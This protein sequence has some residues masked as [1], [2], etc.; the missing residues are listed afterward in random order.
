MSKILFIDVETAPK[1]A[2]VWGLW[3]Q[4]VGLNQLV[5][6][7]YILNWSAKW[8]DED[9]IYTDSLHYHKLWNR[10]P[11]NDRIILE[12][13]WKLLDEAD[14]VVGHNGNRFDIPTINTR[15]L[16]HG[17]Q[18]P[19]SYKK[20]DT[21]KVVRSK[22]RFTSNKLEFLA[23]K[24]LGESKIDTGGFELWRSI[25]QDH[26]TKAFDRM[27]EYCEHDVFLLEKIYKLIAPWHTNHPSTVVQNET[28]AHQCNVCGSERII[29]NG[30]YT[31]Q[32]S[33]YQKY[34]CNDCGHSMRDGTARKEGGK[35]KNLRLRSC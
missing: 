13:L 12:D 17:M 21:L 16:C 14:I 25:I 24:L 6:D 32:S 35:P 9:Y 33:I 8:L 10:E 5:T 28:D 18:P 22:F 19:S 7:T 29:K 3:R 15:F 30:S 11:E 2:Y 4:N 31:T 34:K 27:V 20:V 1:L 26:D 23:N